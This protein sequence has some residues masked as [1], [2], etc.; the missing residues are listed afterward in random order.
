MTIQIHM[1][2]GSPDAA[3]DAAADF[4]RELGDTEPEVFSQQDGTPKRIDPGTAIG[5]ASLVL[6]VPSVVMDI[7]DRLKRR[8]V[9]ERVEKLKARLEEFD[10][11]AELTLND[12]TA[13]DLRRAS[14][15]RIVDILMGGD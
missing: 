11:E 13:V 15:D 8:Q 2:G 10:T 14:T 3:S 6:T 5:L 12:K 4:L 7:R 1:H 9:N